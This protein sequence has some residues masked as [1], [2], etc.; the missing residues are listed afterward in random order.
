M[1]RISVSLS[2]EEVA[3]VDAERGVQSRSSFVRSALQRFQLWSTPLGE[4]AP[5]TATWTLTTADLSFVADEDLAATTMCPSCGVGPAEPCKERTV[6]NPH[7]SRLLQVRKL[8]CGP[9]P[10]AGWRLTPRGYERD[11]GSAKATI[12]LSLFGRI[13]YRIEYGD[14]AIFEES[15]DRERAFVDVQ[16][17]IERRG[18]A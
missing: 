4:L 1:E 8:V 15:A 10:P 3:W 18:L 11:Y 9:P 12:R 5:E 2:A 7:E 6:A 14:D 16:M 17:D 13:E